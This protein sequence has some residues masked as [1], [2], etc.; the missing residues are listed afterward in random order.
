[1]ITLS[2]ICL[3]FIDDFQKVLNFALHSIRVS[4]FAEESLAGQVEFLFDSF[5]LF[6]M[7]FEVSFV[8]L[9]FLLNFE[10]KLFN[11]LIFFIDKSFKF[12]GI[13]FDVVVLLGEGIKFFE[14]FFVLKRGFVEFLNGLFLFGSDLVEVFLKKSDFFV[15]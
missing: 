13:K 5:K 8:L 6:I 3:Q 9:F 11:L 10:G 14:E 15:I 7:S 4:L 1:M 2:Q 12:A